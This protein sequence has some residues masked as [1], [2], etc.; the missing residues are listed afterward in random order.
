MIEQARLPQGY[1]AQFFREATS[2]NEI[3]LEYSD[4][5]KD[6]SCFAPL[7]LCAARQSRGK[8]TKGRAWVSK[9]D[10]NLYCSL[11]FQ[12]GCSLQNLSQLSLIAGIALF[13]SVLALTEN[14]RNVTAQKLSGLRLKWPNDLMI[15]DAKLA[16][17][18]VETQANLSLS[19]HF[20]ILGTGLNVQTAP[21][22]SD[23]K[24]VCLAQFGYDIKPNQAL[25]KLSFFTDIWLN[26]WYLGASFYDITSAWI[27]RA[28]I[29]NELIVIETIAFTTFQGHCMGCNTAG[30]FLLKH[31]NKIIKIDFQTINSI[32]L[33]R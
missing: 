31:E 29:L 9:S 24:T 1:R 15:K 32:T 17:I 7:W 5:I 19:A 14:P 10:Q 27:K 20:A 22:L 2:T 12:P 8:G 25:E 4:Y 26:R 6:L 30:Q 13:D 21:Q 18:L 33:L 28:G 3:A 16:G 11:L 23:K